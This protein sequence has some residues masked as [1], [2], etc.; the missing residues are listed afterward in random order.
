MGN[1]G[2]ESPF[3]SR[4]ILGL[5]AFEV[6]KDGLFDLVIITHGSSP[7]V[8]CNGLS[9][10]FFLWLIRCPNDGCVPKVASNCS[11]TN[12]CFGAIAALHFQS[13]NYRFV[14]RLC[15]NYFQKFNV[16]I[17]DPFIAVFA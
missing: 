11:T 15:E 14:P 13:S 3:Q 12:G 5:V 10:I 17:R 6:M 8:G 16:V 4:T 9:A 7:M 2:G 1:I